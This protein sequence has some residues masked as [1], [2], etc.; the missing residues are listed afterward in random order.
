MYGPRACP[1]GLQ[2]SAQGFNLVSTLGSLIINGS[3]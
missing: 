3:P 1:A 2:D